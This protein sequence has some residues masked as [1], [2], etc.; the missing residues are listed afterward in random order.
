[1]GSDFHS[2]TQGLRGPLGL[3]RKFRVLP[4]WIALSQSFQTDYSPVKYF[5]EEKTKL[6][7]AF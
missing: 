2:A 5:Q 3:H 4:I 6:E 7:A 1:M